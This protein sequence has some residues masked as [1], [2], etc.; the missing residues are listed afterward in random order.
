MKLG[1]VVGNV[2]FHL[3]SPAFQGAR[4]LLVSP[5]GKDELTGDNSRGIS[6]ESSPVVY[7]K[8]GAGVGDHILYVEGSE[9]TQPFD[10]PIPLDAISVAIIDDHE[11]D[12]PALN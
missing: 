12:P 5:M 7:D 3:S 1:R 4:W 11:F 6:N 10:G 2:T 9:A 8:L